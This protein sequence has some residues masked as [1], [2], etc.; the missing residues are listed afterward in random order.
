MAN[1]PSSIIDALNEERGVAASSGQSYHMLKLA[2]GESALTRFLPTILGPRGTWFARIA[3]HWVNNR[4]IVCIRQTSADFGGDPQAPCILCD[5]EQKHSQSR[6][7]D[8]AKAARRIGAFP[9]WLVYVF[10]W[11][12]INERGHHLPTPKDELFIPNEHWLTRDSFKEVSDMWKRSLEKTPEYGFLDPELGY[13]IVVSRDNKNG[14]HHQRE[15]PS[16]I[17]KGKTVDEM[18]NIVDE[19]MKRT[20]FPD[21]GTPTLDELE[22]AYEKAE[23]AILN[24]RATT[25][26]GSESRADYDADRHTARD[27]DRRESTREPSARREYTREADQDHP[28][29]SERSSR[30]AT[31]REPAPAQERAAP[32]RRDSVSRSTTSTRTP[33]GRGIDEREL[34]SAEIPSTDRSP[35]TGTVEELPPV[36]SVGGTATPSRRSAPPPPAR[37]I[38]SDPEQLP[39]EQKDPAPAAEATTATATPQR[40]LSESMSRRVSRIGGSQI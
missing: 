8:I 17:V 26:R 37:R 7:K 27:S 1:V 3:R 10:V 12:I 30:E 29:E 20:K 34:D 22:A 15:D 18:F 5:L 19:A 40:R 9:K 32:S 11:E 39:R 23:D 13:D 28:R 35:D 16:P 24:S 38:D 4:P 25:T 31:N 6:D 33:G 21:T 2:R 14:L 36:R